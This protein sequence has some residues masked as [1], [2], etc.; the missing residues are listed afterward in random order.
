[1]ITSKSDCGV[2]TTPVQPSGQFTTEC[3]AT[4]AQ[5]DIGTLSAGSFPGG[6]F[7]LVS[8]QFSVTVTSGQQNVTVPANSTI[9]L[10]YVR[11]GDQPKTLDT[12]SSPHACPP[13]VQPSGQFTTECTA[14]GAQADIGTLSAGS[15]PGGTFQLVS[16]QFSVTVTSGQQNVTVPANSTITLQYVRQGDQPKTLDTESSPHAC[17]P[18]VQP[19]GQ[20]TTEC[21]A[22]GAQADIGTL[23][24]GSFPGGTFQLVSG[25][26]SVT[27]TSG[28]QNVTVPANSTITLQYVRQGDQ[29]KTLDTE[30]SPHACPPVVQPSGQFTT[31]C[32][33]TGAQADIGTLSAGSF[34]GGT[35]Q[36]VSGQFS[37][38]VTSGQQNVTVP[39]SSTI[40]LQYLPPEG[41]TKTLDTEQSPAACP[42][43]PPTGDV[44]KTSVPATGSVVPPGST[45]AYTVTVSNTGTVPIVNAPVVDTLPTFVTAVAGTVSDSGVVSADGRTITWTV[46][47]PVGGSKAFTYTGLVG[48]NAPP[49]SQLVNK[50]TFLL[51]DSTTTHVVGSGALSLTKAVSPVAGNGVVVEFGDTLTYTLTAAATGTLSQPN[52]VITDY[53]PGR[54]PARPSSGKTKY[55]AGSAACVGAGTCTVTGPD[56][57]GLITWSLGDMAPGTSRQVTF[58]VVIVDVAGEA[59][60]TVAV[61]ILNA[62]AVKSDRTPVTPSNEVVTPVTK[63]LGTKTPREAAGSSAAERAAAHRN[64]PSAGRH[65]RWRPGDGRHGSAADRCQSPPSGADPVV[66]GGA[67]R[68][69][70]QGNGQEAPD[71][72]GLSVVAA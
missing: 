72:R 66:A 46:S 23:S 50:A 61:D 40:T 6:T 7:Q 1:M 34:P 44:V 37:V 36:L 32:T 56:A 42:P 33:A 41:A 48:A 2:L 43:P 70:E 19:S 26:F 15:F 47:L 45:I 53:L 51:K 71:V 59:G 55:V 4:G 65:R 58:K 18:V 39:A 8:G 49:N 17:P 31:E 38:T 16:G 64:R 57:N 25:Q 68:P 10:Q 20:F 28:Q 29:P 60:E 11:Q 12:E 24:A 69:R 27:V 3:T 30:S 9:T 62:G 5:A 54:D 67:G 13:V 21:T 22:T 63:V 35:F 52:V 14:T